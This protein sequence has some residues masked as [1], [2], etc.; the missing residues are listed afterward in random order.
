[1]T[2]SHLWSNNFSF[3]KISPDIVTLTKPTS[4]HQNTRLPWKSIFSL[5]CLA[6]LI[7]RIQKMLV[8]ALQ[9]GKK[10]KTHAARYSGRLSQQESQEPLWGRTFPHHSFVR[11]SGQEE[12]SQAVVNLNQN[13]CAQHLR[14]SEGR[15]VTYSTKEQR[16]HQH[17]FSYSTE[18]I[19]C[20][21]HGWDIKIVK[22][23][24]NYRPTD[25]SV[26]LEFTESYSEQRRR[27]CV[28]HGC[29]PLIWTI[30][31]PS[32]AHI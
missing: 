13:T 24:T 23:P 22:S 26:S 6:F 11:S 31:K 4:R 25:V 3:Q 12:L 8:C 14:W 21:G 16:G 20:W 28:P 9:E 17:L 32:K 30:F 2:A 29:T 19:L 10:K 15:S 18:M 27:W 7:K 5:I 1:M